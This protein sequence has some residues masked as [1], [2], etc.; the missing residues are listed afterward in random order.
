MSYSDNQFY[1]ITDFEPFPYEGVTNRDNPPF[2]WPPKTL[3]NPIA[4]STKTIQRGYLR[5]LSQFLDKNDSA[6]LSRR[7]LHFQFNPDVI[8]R[9]VAARNDIQLWYNMDPA[10]MA[11]PIPGDANFAFELLFNREAE[12]NSQF[13][14]GVLPP[15]AS[16]PYGYSVADIGVLK[17]LIVLDELIGQGIN[18]EL[19]DAMVQRAQAG[20]AYTLAQENTRSE[21]TEEEEDQEPVTNDFN[22]SDTRSALE[23]NWG[24]SAFLISMPIRV[25]FSSLFMVEGFVT[26]TTVMFNKFTPTMV[27]VQATVGVQMQAMYMGFGKKKTFFTETFSKLE[28]DVKDFEGKVSEENKATIEL[29]KKLFKKVMAPG[30]DFDPEDQIGVKQLLEN[31]DKKDVRTKYI[32]VRASDELQNILSSQKSISAIVPEGS[33]T[34]TYV[35]NSNPSNVPNNLSYTNGRQWTFPIT[36]EKNLNLKDLDNSNKDPDDRITMLIEQGANPLGYVWDTSN[37]SIYRISFE[38]SFTVELASGAYI[39]AIQK[40]KFDETVN[41]DQ[42]VIIGNESTLVNDVAQPGSGR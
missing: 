24:N 11:Q 2:L 36:F 26:Q 21:T 38:V 5:M 9:S 27:P 12:V 28:D 8:T 1:R 13:T 33:F 16:D 14:G 37:T 15:D 42:F 22:A 41:W 10:Q 30:E 34:V 31:S 23:S 18:R 19:I 39:N 32:R 4:G 3:R 25:V 35:G 17:D 7:R 40:I 20:S 29:G 6:G